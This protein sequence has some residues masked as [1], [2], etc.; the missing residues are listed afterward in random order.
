VCILPK[1]VFYTRLCRNA[2]LLDSFD[3]GAVM[4][5]TAAASVI[6]T[7]R[8]VPARLLAGVRKDLRD[9]QDIV[10]Q[11]SNEALHRVVANKV[12]LIEVSEISSAPAQ[13]QLGIDVFVAQRT[14]RDTKIGAITKS[15]STVLNYLNSKV[16]GDGTAKTLF[17]NV[18][19][20][21]IK[22]DGHWDFSDQIEAIKAECRRSVVE[23]DSDLRKKPE[24][25]LL[26]VLL[27][28]NTAG[29]ASMAL[30]ALDLLRAEGFSVR[31]GTRT[32]VTVT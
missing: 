28:Y 27:T 26:F 32:Q 20:K 25:P 10:L 14:V 13:A 15:I 1:E 12:R 3:S 22:L 2:P 31:R 29:R 11:L 9:A 6:V 7:V 30:R 8:S 5:A 19:F 16:L 18:L 17:I 4:Y 21:P 23:L 24:I